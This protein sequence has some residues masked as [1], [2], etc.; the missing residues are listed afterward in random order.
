MCLDVAPMSSRTN[1]SPMAEPPKPEP[2]SIHA[3]RERLGSLVDD[4]ARGNSVLICRRSKPLAVLLAVSHYEE[5]VETV[6]RDL[7][8]AA[9]MRARGLGVEDWTT[10]GAVEAVVRLLEEGR[11]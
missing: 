6:R 3:A 11:T 8:L 1:R 7:S 9:I 4:A 10:T 5:L 2:I